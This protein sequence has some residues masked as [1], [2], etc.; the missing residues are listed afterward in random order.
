MSR[1]GDLGGRILEVKDEMTMSAPRRKRI[2]A[3]LSEADG[4][5]IPIIET[6][7]K[8]M[9]DLVLILDGILHGEPGARFDT[10]SNFESIG[11]RGNN[12]V[13]TSWERALDHLN[14]TFKLLT[15]FRDTEAKL[16][17]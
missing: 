12:L 14:R 9:N 1:D 10:L 4:D 6:T 3:I 17:A 7:S 8:R 13:V 5:V 16:L 15:E 11:G 2:Q